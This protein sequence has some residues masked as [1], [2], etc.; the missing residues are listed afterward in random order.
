MGLSAYVNFLSLQMRALGGSEAQ[1]GL[2]WAI[3]AVLEIPMM[4][5]G[6]R[7]FARYRYGRLIVIGMI[8]FAIT[9]AGMALAAT[10]LQF[11]VVLPLNGISYG[12]F[13]VAIVGYAAESAPSGLS[14]A[15]TADGLR[16]CQAEEDGGRDGVS[17]TVC[18]VEGEGGAEAEGSGDSVL[19]GDGSAVWGG[20][21]VTVAPPLP[22]CSAGNTSTCWPRSRP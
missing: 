1:I 14:G 15:A 9:F 4:F 10:P 22:R 2:A 19:E 7:W 16:R 18:D 8:G 21:P 6:A 12:I 11:L 5:M 3:N 20:A 17:G 13:W